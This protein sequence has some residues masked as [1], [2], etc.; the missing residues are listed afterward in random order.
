MLAVFVACILAAVGLIRRI[1]WGHRLAVGILAVNIVGDTANAFL[2]D[3]L[4][5]LIGVP[6]GAALIFYLLRP[7]IVHLYRRSANA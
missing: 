5:T 6:V 1:W 2:R 3:D 7:S 4:R